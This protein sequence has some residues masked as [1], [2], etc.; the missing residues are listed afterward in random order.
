MAHHPV[1]RR[2]RGGLRRRALDRSALPARQP[3][4]AADRA[5]P[6]PTGSSIVTSPTEPVMIVLKLSFLV[7]LVLASPVILWQVWAFLSP[8]LYCAGE[9]GPGTGALRGHLLFLVGAV[10]AFHFVVPQALRVLFSF[11]TE[12]ISPFITYDKYFGFVLQVVLALGL[13]FELPLIIIILSWLGVVGPAELNKF[14]R[15]AVVLSFIAG[16][17]AVAGHRRH[18]DVHDDGSAAP[19]LRGRASPGSVIVH[20]RRRRGRDRRAGAAAAPGVRCVPRRG[21]GRRCLDRQTA[22]AHRLAAR[23]PTGIR[24]GQALDTATAARLGLP[25]APSRSFADTG[26]GGERAPPAAGLPAT[27][28]RADSAT[29]FVQG[30]RVLLKGEALTERQGAVLEADTDHLSTRTSASWTPPASRACST[31][32]RVMVG[33]GSATTPADDEAWSTTRSPTSPRAPPSGSCGATSPRTRAPAGI[34]AG[35]SEITSCDLPTPHYHFAAREV[36]WISQERAR[37]PSGGAL[38]ARRPD[39]LA[40]VHLP[41]HAA[42]TALR[43][44]GAAVRH[45]R[46][47]PAQPA[48]TTGRSPTSATTGPR[49]TTS[50]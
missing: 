39:P 41:G 5:L 25:T 28:Y 33:T 4:Q 40:A 9:E 7:G 3:A 38:R 23:T 34:Y 35:S 32:V 43:H 12:A 37:G 13:S 48:A 8:A 31:R 49:T 6:A 22:A 11:Q 45:Q 24:P 20:R 17:A 26:F 36:K 30:E 2:A 50:T 29:V 21:A 14:R 42:G 46:P 18:L 1:T 44:P 19:A 47:R 27:R 15:Y 16:A 10:L